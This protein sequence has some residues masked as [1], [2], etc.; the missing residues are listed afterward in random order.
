MLIVAS[1]A[2]VVLCFALFAGSF[3]S[4]VPVTLASDRSG[5]VMETGAKVKMRGVDVGQVGSISGGRQ[6]VR[7]QLQ[8]DPSQVKYIPANVEAQIKATT[9]FG[10]KYV[11]LIY[12]EHPSPRRLSAGAVLVSRNVSTEVN[13]VSENLVGLL[14]QIDPAK[15][16]AVLTTLADGLRGQ[17]QTIGEAITDANQV[18]S[19]VN[20]RSETIRRDWQSLAAFSDTYGAA[21]HNIL[22]ILDAVST[23]SATISDHEKALDSL[24]LNAIGVSQSGTDLIGPNKD[25]FIRSINILEPTT[26][27]LMK[28]N[29]EYTCLI[30][31][32]T[33]YQDHGG[34]ANAGGGNGYSLITDTG[35][36]GGNDPYVYPDNLPIVAAK[37]GPGGKPGCGSLPDA[38]KN[39]PVRQLV[40][41]SGWGT[42]MDIRP[43]FGL[44][45]PCYEQFFQVTRAVPQP[46]SV[47]CQGLPSPGLP[48][49]PPGPLPLPPPPP[50]ADPASAPPPPP[51]DPASAPP[52]P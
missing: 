27:L 24:L 25:N 18:L 11:D 48:I 38:S 16:N 34:H 39:F 19:A 6:P 51:A 37:G 10:A 45:H 12:P 26:S 23:T 15:L 21:A 41:N 30:L 43:N 36:L 52:P 28:Y 35:L 32:T 1:V 5:L 44:G 7:L 42:G 49:P 3:T 20:P 40:T 4:Y 22:A 50:P 2:A 47:R 14:H 9:A 31:G 33:W 17:G 13:T 8:I 29:P 46:P